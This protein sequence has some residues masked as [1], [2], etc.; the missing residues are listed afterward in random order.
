MRQYSRLTELKQSILDA[1]LYLASYDDFEKLSDIAMNAYKDYPL[2]NWFSNGKYDKYI[3]KKI[4]LISLKSLYKTG[5][6]YADKKDSSGFVI[7]LPPGFTG[8]KILPFIYHGGIDLVFRYGLK[9]IFKLLS[10]ENFAMQ[11]KK[12]HT[13]NKDLYL[14]NLCVQK[15][16]Q[17][18]KIASKLLD[19][20]LNFCDNNSLT[21]YLETNYKNNVSLYE[22]F[23]F[24]LKED[25]FIPNT[26]V[27]HYAMVKN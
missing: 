3:S 18:N 8:N 2:H 15:N 17:G 19:P 11:L 22:H 9:I 14:Y 1:G 20:I 16:A 24:T 13:G 5:I 10:Y 25:T 26:N 21:C 7:C 27:N 4:M 23:G 12:K 6:V